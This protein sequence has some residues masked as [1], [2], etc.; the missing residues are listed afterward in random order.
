MSNL[1][2]GYKAEDEID[3]FDLIDDIKDKWYWL[4]G[5]TVVGVALAVLYAL[6]ATPT[7]QTELVYKEADVTGLLQL[8]QPRLK[9]TYAVNSSG[10]VIRKGDEAV[11][12]LSPSR[13]LTDIERLFKSGVVKRQFYTSLLLENNN[14]MNS[15]IYNDTLTEEQN[16]SEFFRKLHVNSSDSNGNAE[17]DGGGL[18]ISFELSDPDWATAILNRFGLFVLAEYERRVKYRVD[19]AVSGVLEHY[20]TW[21][22]SLRASYNA[23]IERRMVQL[24][25]AANIASSINQ[26]QPF[27][28]SKDTSI[29]IQPPLYMMGEKALRKEIE[30]LSNRNT[31]VG[32]NAYINGMSEL[33]W[34][35]K[36]LEG[37]VI[38]WSA[39]EYVELDQAAI[40][41]LRPI[42]PRKILVV[43]LGG[44]AGFMAGIMFALL[45]AANVRRKEQ[46]SAKRKAKRPPHWAA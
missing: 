24:T 32:E 26:Q 21:E 6:L 41:P 11:F 27:F 2:S 16:F 43:V 37:L 20:K 17:D 40:V 30:Q 1:E 8:N 22:A 7:Y 36:F 10:V 13:A 29:T 31:G 39:V 25:E 28:S 19:I 9:E 35:I 34:N 5:T 12:S 23:G 15:F 45:A 44:V 14:E 4:V 38:D 33:L 18:E 42:K 3:L 46:K